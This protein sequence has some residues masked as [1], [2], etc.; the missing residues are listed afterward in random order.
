MSIPLRYWVPQH[1]PQS[2][3]RGQQDLL[4]N[5][6]NEL[7]PG[8]YFSP[9]SQGGFLSVNNLIGC[10]N[11]P[12]FLFT[13]SAARRNGTLMTFCDFLLILPYDDL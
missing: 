3:I 7:K 5:H 11:I 12:F 9:P 2:G 4:V 8:Q 6:S 13:K 1:G 10:F